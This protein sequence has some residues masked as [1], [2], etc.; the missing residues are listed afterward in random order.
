[1]SIFS[2]R[3]LQAMLDELDPRLTLDKRA[4]FWLLLNTA[5]HKRPLRL[6]S[7][8]GFSGVWLRSPILKWSLSSLGKNL[9]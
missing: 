9:R 7:K 8:L 5:M 1:M 4:M 3:R 6:N 2:R